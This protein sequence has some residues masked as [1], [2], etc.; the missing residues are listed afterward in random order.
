MGEEEVGRYVLEAVE[1]DPV[2]F[3]SRDSFE[4]EACPRQSG[5]HQDLDMQEVA[6]VVMANRQHEANSIVA[7]VRFRPQLLIEEYR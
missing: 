6:V 7:Q 3:Y 2:G 5:K 4:V 1:G